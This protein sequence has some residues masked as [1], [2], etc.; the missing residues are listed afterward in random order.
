MATKKTKPTPEIAPA[1]DFVPTGYLSVLTPASGEVLFKPGD[2]ADRIFVLKAGRV[3]IQAAK[4]SAVL[5]EILGP[6]DVFGSI[7]RLSGATY[8]ELATATGAGVEVWSLHAKDLP[9]LTAERPAV[10]EQIMEHLIDRADRLSNRVRSFS[11][12]EVPSRLADVLLD[13]AERHGAICAHRGQF[14]LPGVSQGDLADLIGSS[15]PYASTL[16]NEFSRM[17]L[18]KMQGRTICVVNQRGLRAK[19]QLEHVQS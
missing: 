8:S 9:R 7:P 1:D 12:K 13:L 6:E 4:N 14:D 5:M 17:G 16:F 10:A 15:R 18:V 19:A 3:R 11:Y 2:P